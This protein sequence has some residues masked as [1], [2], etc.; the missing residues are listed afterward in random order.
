MHRVRIGAARSPLDPESTRNSLTSFRVAI[1]P[2][3]E[4]DR[5]RAAGVACGALWALGHY[6]SKDDVVLV[7]DNDGNFHVGRITGPYIYAPEGPLRHRRPVE[8]TGQLILREE[9]SDEMWR[10]ARVP[11]SSVDLDKYAHEISALLGFSDVRPKIRVEAEDVEDPS[12]FA[13]ERHLEDFLVANWEQ[14]VLASNWKL[15]E[16]D[17]EVVGQQFPSDTGP[18]DLLAI[19][20]DE[21]E[22]LVIELKKGRASDTVVGQ[23]QR[24]MGYVKEALTDG[25]QIVKGMIIAL[26]DDLRIQRALSVTTN[27]DFYRYKVS[28]DLE[29][30]E[31]PHTSH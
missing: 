31:S 10:S 1:Q 19:S 9:L 17:G 8:W 6:R 4:T 21:S 2:R 25:S 24:Y 29:K 28:F 27:I 5:G 11:L 22:I 15:W 20:H 14:T 16:E 30:A 12:V 26:E 3:S 13:L 7:I 18:I 23:I